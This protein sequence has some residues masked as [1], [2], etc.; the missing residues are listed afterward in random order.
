MKADVELDRAYDYCQNLAKSHYE[1]FPVASILLPKR[2]RQP[3]SVIYAFARTADDFADEGDLSQAT[4]LS[5]LNEYSQALFQISQHDYQGNNPIFIALADVIQKHYLPIELFEKLLSAFKQDVVKSRYTDF[6]EV[7]DYCTRSADPVGRLLLHLNGD[8]TQEQLQQ[9]DAV[10]SALQLINFYQ[11]IVQDYTEQ[12]RIYIPQDELA[13]S[14]LI[15]SDL[16][17]PATDKIAPL[18]RSLYKR[19]QHLMTKGAALGASLQGRMGWE[20]RAM[21]L[22]GITT[23]HQLN[24]QSDQNLLTRPRLKKSTFIAIMFGSISAWSYQKAIA[25]LLQ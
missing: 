14:G 6:D 4:R 15:E 13:Q 20:V 19:T 22:G 25:K 8:P 12:D 24:M 5:Q 23:L 1:N 7:L 3:I 18:L 2:L 21:T 16:V 17:D 10:C 9:S 11:D